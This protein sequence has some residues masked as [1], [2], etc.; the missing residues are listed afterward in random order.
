LA[1]VVQNR[2]KVAK[3][4]PSVEVR[5]CML[6]RQPCQLRLQRRSPTFPLRDGDQGWER[7]SGGDGCRQARQLGI[8]PSE[9]SGEHSGAA[10]GGS[11]RIEL[12]ERQPGRIAQHGR[13]E[14]TLQTLEDGRV[15]GGHRCDQA[16]PADAGS[17]P[18]VRRAG[19]DV[20]PPNPREPAPYL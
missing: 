20:G 16:V 12:V 11:Q 7:P 6:R 3:D 18:M 2:L 19:V 9:L 15:H 1:R 17:T 14:E 10:E 5:G 8:D 13:V 4:S